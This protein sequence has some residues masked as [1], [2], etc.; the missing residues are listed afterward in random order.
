MSSGL[1]WYVGIVCATAFF[2]VAG[3]VSQ[4]D[5]SRFGE[6]VPATAM[7]AVLLTL[8][9]FFPVPIR[10][11]NQTKAVLFTS[12]FAF[13]LVPVAGTGAA[14]L[15]HV[16]SSVLADLIHRKPVIKISFNAAQFTLALAAG[17]AVYVAAG[18]GHEITA[19]G[20]PALVAGAAVFALLNHLLVS[21]AVSL[22]E[23]T[24]LRAGLLA[25]V[26]VELIT[27]ALL[28]A[29]APVAVVVAEHA[30]FLVPTLVSPLAAVYLASK[31]WAEANLRRAEAEAAAERQRRLTER[32]QEV[33]RR[34]QEADR[35][36]ADLL[37]TVTHELR[38][39][40]T[41]IVGALQ[42]LRSREKRMT[43][44]ERQEFVSMGLR[45]GERLQRMIEQLLLAA[46]FERRSPEA[47]VAGAE[48]VELDASELV[49]QAREE[50]QARHGER[51]ITVEAN[52]ALPVRAVQDVVAQVLEN[53]I[54]NACK[55]SPPRRPVHLS[56][57]RRNGNAVLAVEDCG[58]GV[59]PG[60]RER[61]FERFTQL[62]DSSEDRGG[63]VGLGLYIA[64]QLARSQGGELAVTEPTGTGGARFELR[65]PLDGGRGFEDVRM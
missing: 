30:L 55:Y 58:P 61:I 44:N 62:D 11:R 37:A 48:W 20:L 59:A 6:A 24:P 52:G 18:G 31:G 42:L 9:E 32:E 19:R 36:K 41:T 27:S 65:L 57:T 39:P 63:G 4:I 8:G 50:A 49:R 33:I 17:G 45:Q 46:R 56:G 16:A 51:P 60:D 1:R 23:G 10:H 15:A 38:S 14:V 47:A 64:R 2:T 28:L 25:D 53:L 5:V 26:R 34:L 13:A 7:F 43:S 3:L 21:V 22:A 54:D 12:T 35:M 29:L 40:L